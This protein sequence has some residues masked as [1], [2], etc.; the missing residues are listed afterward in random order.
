MSDLTTYSLAKA[1]MENL[2]FAYWALQTIPSMAE[3]RFP[4]TELTF[5]KPSLDVYWARFSS[6][7][8]SGTK[9][10]VGSSFNGKARHTNRGMV[11]VQFFASMNMLAVNAP[12]TLQALAEGMRDTF[13]S[14]PHDDSVI[15]RNARIDELT[16]DGTFYQY[17]AI[18][19]YEFDE[20]G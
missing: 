18:A 2:A 10:T 19:E 3:I 9:A 1:K 12:A 16:N 4:D 8:V 7:N 6:I 15:Y 20:I 13:R 5:G 11:Y 17:R 14:A